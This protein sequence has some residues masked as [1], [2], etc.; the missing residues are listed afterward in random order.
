VIR[1]ALVASLRYTFVL[2]ASTGRSVVMA[3]V[4]VTHRSDVQTVFS[5]LLIALV[6]ATV[7]LDAY[8]FS[9]L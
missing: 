3:I 1:W 4:D 8:A 5:L 9:T 7:G 6:L 2:E